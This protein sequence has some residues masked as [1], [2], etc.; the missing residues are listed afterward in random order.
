MVRGSGAEG[1]RVSRLEFAVEASFGRNVDL[2]MG[3][4]PRTQGDYTKAYVGVIFGLRLWVWDCLAPM[5]ENDVVECN[6][7]KP[8]RC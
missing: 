3:S 6:N 8:C 5:G 4:V 7:T 1:S 2:H